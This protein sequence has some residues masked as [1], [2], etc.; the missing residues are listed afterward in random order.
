MRR[1]ASWLVVVTVLFGICS[2]APAQDKPAKKKPAGGK[3]VKLFDGESLEGWEC[4]TIAPDVKREDVWSVQDGILVCKGEPLGYLHTKKKYANYKLVVVW[5][6][7]PDTEPGNNGI[8]LRVTGDAVDFLPKC[9]ECQL[10]SGS[11]GDLY[12]FHGYQLQG[13]EARFKVIE[14]EKLG[15]IRAV[16]KIKGMEKPP[17]KWNKAEITVDGGTITVVVNGEKVNEATDC[18]VVAGHIGL[19]SEGGQ[20]HF[21]RV[22]LTPIEK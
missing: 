18:D 3:L 12:G 4:F 14:H 16:E 6:W 10:K 9:A 15:Q 17:G 20:I 7:A 5:R 19:Q 13:D 11:A 21:R 2:A 22:A 8:L 1:I